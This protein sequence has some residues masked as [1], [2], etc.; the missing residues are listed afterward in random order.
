MAENVNSNWAPPSFPTTQPPARGYIPND[1]YGAGLTVMQQ[2][3]SAY[4]ESPASYPKFWRAP[5]WRA[6][7]PIVTIAVGAVS[8]FVISTIA[9][10]IAIVVDHVSGRQDITKI[11]SMADLEMTPMLFVCTNL[12][13]AA[14]IPISM[15]MGRLFFG[16]KGRFLSSVAG[17]LRW[18]WLAICLAILLPIWLSMMFAS[19]LVEPSQFD[20]LA[21]NNE[22][23]IFIAIILVT[24]PLQCAGEE[25]GF[26]GL[27]NRSVASFIKPDKRILGVPAGALLGIIISSL[28]FMAAHAASDI[29]L[30]SFYFLFGVIACVLAWR[31]G[32]LEA[33]IAMHVVNNITAMSVL[34]FGD[35]EGL[36][37]RS[38]GVADPT[39][40]IQMA[41][42]LIGMLLILFA[43]NKLGVQIV[44]KGEENYADAIPDGA[45]PTQHAPRFPDD[46]GAGESNP[47]A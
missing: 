11:T 10:I 13:L 12:S 27:I 15:L 34:P 21:V 3:P 40:L 33:A 7:R 5:N 45:L 38:A 26:R 42:P 14:F 8:F 32:G 44:S 2:K 16:Q 19:W 9:A 18:K 6:W 24:T 35:T 31:T 46:E 17:G 23:V 25:F 39:A 28:L 37:D 4:P 20:G 47:S 1:T 22:T 43:A 29:W 36:L 41:A 30:N